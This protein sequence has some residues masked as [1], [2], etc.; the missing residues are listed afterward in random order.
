MGFTLLEQVV[1]HL[2]DDDDAAVVVG[3]RRPAFA[4]K[5]ADLLAGYGELRDQPLRERMK[6]AGIVQA[7]RFSWETSV[8]RMIE[9]Y[10]EVVA[11][12]QRRR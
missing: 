12:H 3:A 10:G 2:V 4:R 9:I 6:A 1:G 8:R 7:Q 5:V 11:E